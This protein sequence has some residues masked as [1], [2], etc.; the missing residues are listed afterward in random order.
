[1]GWIYKITNTIN[2]KVYV[3]QTR[4]SI[5]HR[6]SQHKCAAPDSQ[7]HQDMQLL[8]VDNFMIDTLE[9]CPN[10]QLND[11]EMY[12]INYYNSFNAGY[13]MTLGGG[14]HYLNSPKVYCYTLKGNLYKT[15]ANS[16]EACEDNGIELSTLRA[17][18][19]DPTRNSCAGFQWA[20]EDDL[21]RIKDLS[22]LP[23]MRGQIY[24]IILQY[25]LKG[26]FIAEYASMEEAAQATQSHT[27]GIARCIN[28]EIKYSNNYIWQRGF[29]GEPYPLHIEVGTEIILN[30]GKRRKVQMIQGSAIITY[31]SL[32]EAAR[33]TGLSRSTITRYCEAYP[34]IT[35]KGV[36][37]RYYEE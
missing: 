31:N 9:E 26:D 2:D 10:D 7:L 1:M 28:N 35:S 33:L 14:G 22:I 24:G 27:S 29:K 16:Y 21:S 12:W 5:A 34:Q 3:G 19:T 11:R 8:G 18:L 36:Q 23:E 15:Y 17:C 25:N 30:R 37:Y 32:S 20:Y 6:F 4:Y 13:N